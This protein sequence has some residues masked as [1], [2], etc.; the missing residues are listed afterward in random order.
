M[1]NILSCMAVTVAMLPSLLRAETVIEVNVDN[2]KQYDVV[3]MIRMEGSGGLSAFSDSIRNG[4]S[5]F[6]YKC[7][8]ITDNVYYAITLQKGHT[9]SHL[10]YIYLLPNSNATISGSGDYTVHWKIRSTHP[11]QDFDNKMVDAEKEILM[12]IDDINRVRNDSKNGEE[13]QALNQKLDTLYNQLSE[14]ELLTMKEMTIDSLWME[15]Y[16]LQTNKII[17]RGK[18]HPLYGLMTELYG[19][20]SEADKATP[21]GRRITNNLFGRAPQAGDNLIDYDL[22][23]LDEKAHH[24]SDY[25]GKWLLM[26][27]SSYYCAPCRYLSSMWKYLYE[28]GVNQKM[29]I[30]TIIDDTKNLYRDML[31]TEKPVSPLFYDHDGKN[32]I[33]SMYKIGVTPTFYFI[34]PDGTIARQW[35]GAYQDKIMQAV[36]EANA[37]P[38]T[39]YK[40]ENDVITISNPIPTK[41]YGFSVDKVEIHKDSVVLDCTM[42]RPG[43]FKTIQRS[44]LYVDGQCVSKITRSSSGFD[45]FVKVPWGDICHFRLTFEPLPAGTTAFDFKEGDKKGDFFFLGMKVKE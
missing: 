42:P 1:K 33:H 14:K 11:K 4:K 20:L 31:E 36:K 13:R 17:S 39:S 29:E 10:R 7:D 8:T 5:S 35:Q 28:K 22:Y 9:S 18:S 44:G 41:Y 34:K 43:N 21:V 3:Q 26:V 24:L 23:D 15:N 6:S 25:Q 45:N 16:A 12:A 27:F 19:R 38:A 2:I 30:V 37:Y 32:G 40:T